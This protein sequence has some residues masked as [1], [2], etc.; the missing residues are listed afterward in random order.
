MIYT[1]C[2]GPRVDV[3]TGLNAPLP[4]CVLMA[5]RVVEESDVKRGVKV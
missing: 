5:R 3:L 1:R 4:L 2:A